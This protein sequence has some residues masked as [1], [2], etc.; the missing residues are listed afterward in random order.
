MFLWV[1]TKIT[2]TYFH[3]TAY[4]C[5][6]LLKEEPLPIV[7]CMIEMDYQLCLSMFPYAWGSTTLDYADAFILRQQFTT[8]DLRVVR[9]MPMKW[10]ER[11]SW[12]D[13]RHLSGSHRQRLLKMEAVWRH[14]IVHLRRGRRWKKR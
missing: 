4:L 2:R 12:T 8:D 3:T 6:V 7:P 10:I 9:A 11:M 5:A 13:G 1:C 14:E